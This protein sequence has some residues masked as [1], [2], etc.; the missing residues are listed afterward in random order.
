MRPR[1]S[2][3][4]PGR[5]PRPGHRSEKATVFLGKLQKQADGSYL[6]KPIKAIGQGADRVLG[7][8]RKRKV[9]G[10]VEPVSR[11]VK[12]DLLIERGDEG[13]A[14]EDDLVWAEVKNTR[15][16]GPNVA[17]VREIVGRIDDPST[18]SQIAIANHDIRMAFPSEVLAEAE[19]ASLPGPGSHEDLRQTPLITI[20]P[21]DARDH[22]DAVFAEPDPD[23]KNKGGWRTIVAIADVAWFV[24]PGSRL[25][26]EAQKRGNSTY[27]P[28]MVVP[29]LPERLSNDLCSLRENEDRPALAVEMRFTADGRK[30]DHRFMR[31]L[32]RSHARLSYSEVQ[33]AIDG[34]PNDR[35]APW[36]DNVLKPLWGAYASLQK[37]RAK[38][39][40]LDLDLPERRIIF[41]RNGHV[42]GVRLKERFD[43]NRLIEEFMIQANVCAAES[44]E[45]AKL[46]LIY[47]VH[48]DPDPEKLEGVR[49]FLES[50]GYSLPKG[51]VLRPK[52]LNQTL[53]LAAEKDEAALVGQVLLRAQR[54]A[55][56]DTDNVGH[57]GLNLTR[58]AHF[59]SP[60][61]RYADLTVHRA[62]I[63]AGN[64]GKGAQSEE[65]AHRLQKIAETISDL[66]R[67][68]MAAEREST[69]R[70]LAAWLEDRIG[71]EFRARINGV[72]RSGLFVTLDDTGADGFIPARSIGEEYFRH[73]EAFNALVGE[74]S[75]GVYRLGQPVLVRLKE[76]TP[77][78]GGLLFEMLSEPLDDVTIPDSRG[79]R[80]SRKQDG[81]S[82]ARSK[83]KKTGR[84]P[85]GAKDTSPGKRKKNRTNRNKGKPGGPLG[86]K[87]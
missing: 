16:Y 70:F 7:V 62:L 31:I 41:D 35:A 53:K 37:A 72:T 54:Q 43:A 5:P 45:Q 1:R 19:A 34:T 82:P 36:L 64:L 21:A 57:F 28:D 75:G 81:R 25:D 46:P 66:E 23:K 14:T 13:G 24:T 80:R 79:K 27:L 55:V 39:S 20:D 49:T 73:H 47:R 12:R 40:P 44:L 30:L 63:A 68:S 33:N 42:E 58:Y 48:G 26:R 3:W 59:T 9:G 69:D 52:N 78:Q 77:L 65:E 56:Y 85:A 18:Y 60:I 74:R 10:A 67:A 17:R 71:A 61:R 38:R 2:C 32:M 83:T 76:V 51:Q 8:Y 15:G 86:K 4:K 87:K 50:L 22:D 84:K 29:M 11:K 6:T